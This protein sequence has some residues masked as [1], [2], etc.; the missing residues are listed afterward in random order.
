[1]ALGPGTNVGSSSERNYCF[2]VEWVHG[3]LSIQNLDVAIQY[4]NGVVLPPD[5]NYTVAAVAGN[6]TTVAT[7][8]FSDFNGVEGPLWV[9]AVDASVVGGFSFCL[10]TGAD[11]LAGLYFV[12]AGVGFDPTGEITQPIPSS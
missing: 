7:Y 6:G 2:P 1:M 8:Y 10:A 3:S 11:N 12:L 9:G 5:R 4:A